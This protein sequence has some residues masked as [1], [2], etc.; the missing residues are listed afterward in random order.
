VFQTPAPTLK[1]RNA[2]LRELARLLD[3][4]APERSNPRANK[5]DGTIQAHRSPNGCILQADAA[6]LSVTWYAQADDQD[7]VG[8]LQIILWSGVV[9]RRGARQPERPAQVVRQ[10][11]VNPIEAPV[12]ETVWRSHDGTPYT[13]S[14]LIAHCQKLLDDQIQAASAS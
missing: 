4:L 6:A 10:E 3:E 8:E 11:V 13:T 14:A 1:D 2:M 12:D 7:R 5:P 9:A